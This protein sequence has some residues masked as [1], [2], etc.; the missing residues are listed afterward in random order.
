[1]QI[2]GMP[3]PYNEHMDSLAFL[4]RAARAKPLPLYVLHGDESFL[5][6]QT[7][8]AIRAIVV[9]PDADDGAI[10]PSWKRP[11]ARCRS[12]ARSFST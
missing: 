4:E 5:K 6:R 12:T 11:S 2:N 7:L 8:R 1:L 9:G 10:V 3:G